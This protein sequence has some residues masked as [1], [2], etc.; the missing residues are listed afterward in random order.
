[1][2]TVVTVRVFQLMLDLSVNSNDQSFKTDRR[3]RSIPAQIALIV[4]V[5]NAGKQLLRLMK[6]RLCLRLGL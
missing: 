1:M 2:T 5:G 6:N 4:L 3:S